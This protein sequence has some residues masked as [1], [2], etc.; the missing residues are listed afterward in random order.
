MH[1]YVFGAG[2]KLLDSPRR[3]RAK[4]ARI[5]SFVGVV[6]KSRYGRR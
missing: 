5:A 4:V 6:P 2:Y 3:R 1:E